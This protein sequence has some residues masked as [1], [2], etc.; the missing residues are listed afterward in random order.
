LGYLVVGIA[1]IGLGACTDTV[2][3]EGA[4][5]GLSASRTVLGTGGDSALISAVVLESTGDPV[6][7]GTVVFFVASFGELCASGAHRDCASGAE[8]SAAI[9]TKTDGGVAKAIFRTA[10]QSGVVTITGTSGK[11]TGTLSITVSATVA[12]PS[13][14]TV[15]S[16]TPDTVV[17]GGGRALITAYIVDSIGRPVPDNT[18]IS[19]AAK[20]GTVSPRIALTGGGFATAV[21]VAGTVVGPDTVWLESGLVRDSVEVVV[22]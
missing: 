5:I 2:A 4:T 10:S 19:L 3:P 6:V 9:R 17:S 13:S 18:R 20:T 15:L 7:D 22:Q 12:P 11:T 21:F 14:R 8:A 16:I 1:V